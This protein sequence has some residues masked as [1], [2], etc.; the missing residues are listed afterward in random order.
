MISRFNIL[1]GAIR[2]FGFRVWDQFWGLAADVL[3]MNWRPLG[4]PAATGDFRALS[5]CKLGSLS[6]T[7][8]GGRFVGNGRRTT[9]G[10]D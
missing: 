7:D 3:P 5:G 1:Q 10:Q 6:T 2:C 8:A 9:R 4:A